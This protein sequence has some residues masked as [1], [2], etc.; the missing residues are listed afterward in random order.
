MFDILNYYSISLFLGGFVAIFSG[1]AVY[2]SGAKKEEGSAWMLLNL[3]TAVWSFGYFSMIVSN[4]KAN[5]LISDRILHYGAILIPIF[6]FLFILKLVKAFGAYK[7]IFY[8][9]IPVTAFFL[10]YCS[11]ELYVRDVFAKGPFHFVPDAGPFYIYFTMYFF[12]VTV[13][14][15]TVLYDAI[16]NVPKED[17]PRLW[18]V[19]FSSIFGFIGGGSV[20]F[21]TFNVPIP[22][23]FLLEKLNGNRFHL[24]YILF[25]CSISN[26][27]PFVYMV[28]TIRYFGY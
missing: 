21:L 15:Q 17:K 3:S 13:F 24:E 1:A 22:P 12:S 20:F 2:F 5:A 28:S 4:E 11:S 7:K 16:K 14:A 23:Y 27:L 26:P 8:S 6:Y 9:I 25:F 10:F 19:F 18:W